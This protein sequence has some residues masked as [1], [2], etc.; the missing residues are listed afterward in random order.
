MSEQ[1]YDVFVRDWW[2]M[3]GTKLV[4]RTCAPR[5]YLARGVSETR[6]R[7]ICAEYRATHE[8]GKLSRKAEYTAC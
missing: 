8:P 5:T 4:P 2:R 1:Y 7:E 3:E 6:A